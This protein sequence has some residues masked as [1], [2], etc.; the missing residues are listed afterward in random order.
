MTVTKEQLSKMQSVDD[1]IDITE[2]IRHE[3]REA[4]YDHSINMQQK[5]PE[6]KKLET[7]AYELAV[8]RAE[9]VD[10]LE[11]CAISIEEDSIYND[12]PDEW[13]DNIRIKAYGL[14][15]F[16]KEQ[17]NSSC[18]QEFKKYLQENDLENP[19]EDIEILLNNID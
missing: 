3:C 1:L 9:T 2:T 4:R 11:K 19:L 15:W 16:F 8:E 18:H 17:I 10:E 13:A 12:N 6:Y 14:V 7:C 5:L